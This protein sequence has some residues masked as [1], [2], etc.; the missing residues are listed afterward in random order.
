MPRD[1]AVMSG[2]TPPETVIPWT[3]VIDHIDVGLDITT[4]QEPSV[5]V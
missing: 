3:Y 5:V 4:L 1:F 2:P